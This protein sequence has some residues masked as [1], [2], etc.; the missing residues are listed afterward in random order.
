MDTSVLDS[1]D[2]LLD[3]LVLGLSRETPTDRESF[4][5]KMGFERASG[6]I[7]ANEDVGLRMRF[8]TRLRLA[9]HFSPRAAIEYDS[10]NP[11]PRWRLIQ[12]HLINV[13]GRTEMA[14]EDVARAIAAV[15]DNWQRAREQVTAHRDSLIRRDGPTCRNCH[16][17][18]NNRESPTVVQC[19]EYKPYFHS[20]EELL[21][22]EV[23]HIE[24]ISAMGTNVVQNLQLLCRLCN[25]GKG[26]GLGVDIRHEAAYAGL[27]VSIIPLSHRKQLL[28]AVIE[29]DRRRCAQCD[30]SDRE[31]TLRPVVAD[32]AFVRSN[33]RALCIACAYQ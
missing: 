30:A 5:R 16:V 12:H 29:R 15:L 19:D 26:D 28:Y 23:D 22:A 17:R 33:L 21:S 24:A 25:A 4:Y 6:I 11:T 14:A 1:L 9:L 10:G 31:L 20:P 8:E 13:F 2:T 3:R 18:F 32:G 27:P 7:R